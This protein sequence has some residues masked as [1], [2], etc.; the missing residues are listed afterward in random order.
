MY[1]L[2]AVIIPFWLSVNSLGARRTSSLSFC[3]SFFF[4]PGR[5]P[6]PLRSEPPL[7]VWS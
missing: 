5:L 3:A 4:E 7:W 6:E 2:K 1:R